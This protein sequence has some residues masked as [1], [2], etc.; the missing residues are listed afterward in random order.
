M[1]RAG[2]LGS[3]DEK[4]LAQNEGDDLVEAVEFGPLPA[5]DGSFDSFDIAAA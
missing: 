2:R 4:A 5:T 1:G 3:A